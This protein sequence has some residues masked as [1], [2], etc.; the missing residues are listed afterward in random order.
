MNMR[1]VIQLSRVAF[2]LPLCLVGIAVVEAT[3]VTP[4]AVH[5]I[6]GGDDSKPAAAAAP[7]KTKAQDAK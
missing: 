3:D 7:R 6:V 5:P 4:V 1:L 2:K